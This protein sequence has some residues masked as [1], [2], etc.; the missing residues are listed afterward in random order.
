MA[1]VIL[2][3]AGAIVGNAL[4]PGLGGA[5]L[6]G[7]GQSLGNLIDAQ[8]G[9]GSTV[10]GPRLETLSVQD[11]RYGAGIPLVYGNAR[12]AGNVLWSSDLI[13][14]RH[15]ATNGGKGGVS[16]SV[17]TKTYTYS[18]HCAIGICEGPIAGIETVWA[19]NTV[20]YQNG[21]WTSGLF[22]AATLY[23]GDADQ[24]PN[25]FMQS[26]LGAENVPAHR[27]LAS[28]VFDNL[29]LASFGNR[30][31]NL[32][33]EIAATS[34]TNAPACLGATS[35]A[36]TQR[37][38]TAQNGAMA[39]LALSDGGAG[40]KALVGGA[41][42]SDGSAVFAVSE[43]DVSGE[44]PTLLTAC[45]SA[46]FASSATPS[47]MSWA[48]APDGRFVA[49]H[50][51]SALAVS[52][53]FALYDTKAQS[54]GPVYSLAMASSS[55][56]KQVA[57]LDAHRFVIDDVVNGVRGLRAFARSG[58]AIVDLGFTGLWGSGSGST[59]M[60]FYGAQ[61]TPLA[62]GLLAYTWISG[63]KTLQARRVVWRDD[64]LAL[65]DV[66]TVAANLAIGSGSGP[67]ARFVQT[68]SGEWTLLYG[69]VLYYSLMS[70][71]P[72]AL[73]A[74]I[75]RPWQQI[76]PSFGTSTTHYPLPAGDRLLIVQNNLN[77]GAYLLS[78]VLLKD[79]AFAVGT[80]ATPVSGLSN[81]YS[82]FCALRLD[83][84]R[85]LFTAV[86]GTGYA[87]RQIAVI[88]RA[89]Q[90]SVGGVLADLLSRAGYAAADYDVSALAQTPIQGYVIQE[91]TSAR[92]AIEPL[93]IVA[94][95]DLVETDG[96]LKAVLRG[97]GAVATVPPSEWRAT[98]EDEAPPAPLLIARAEELDLP[99]EVAVEVV[100]PARRFEAT[101]QRARR[102]ASSARSVQKIS[103]PVVCG[104][105]AAKKIAETKLYTAWA[106]RE[107]VKLSVSRTWA[108]LDPA[109]VIHLG[110]GDLLRLASV[111]QSA[112][113]L[114][115]E[116]FY[117][118]AETLDS[119]AAA[120]G[121]L[122]LRAADAGAV[123]SALYL[124]DLPALQSAHDQP[125]VYVAVTGLDG[126]KSAD[127][128]RS[129]DGVAYAAF[130]ASA[131]PATAGI[132]TSV[133]GSSA[134][135]YQDNKNAVSVQMT[136]GTLSSCA[137]EDLLNGANAALLGD[138]IV[139]FQTA[140]LTGPGL[141]TL[142]G[143]LRG[144][145]GTESAVSTHVLGEKFV[146][147]HAG[148]VDFIS[149]PLGDRDKGYTFRAL[150]AGQSLNEAQD[151]TFTYGMRTLKPLSPVRIRGTRSLGSSGDL[152]VTWTRRARRDAEWTD[153][154][155][156]PLDETEE[157]YAAEIMDGE[158]VVR[159]FDALTA[160]TLTYTTEQ[161]A[162]DWGSA[163][164]ATFSVRVCQ[165]S[166]RF[167]RGEPGEAVV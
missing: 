145:R 147:L 166:A 142:S 72:S 167:G 89:K 122:D 79:G 131:V 39:P 107:L 31:P 3:S 63:S 7:V 12:I 129:A 53:S 138:E 19:D 88:E 56:H 151:Y 82:S 146:L 93:Q 18:V 158:T 102:L 120:D 80:E 9:L 22:D 21:L 61:F 125:G 73:G 29:Q 68:G 71:E 57:W 160:P 81:L 134:A 165:I 52:H 6:G 54:F 30:L 161:Q 124:M 1:S 50:L 28:I 119:L 144:R 104:A 130:T 51:Q 2:K 76:T 99:R 116:G 35:A 139:Q 14:T 152:T 47:Q 43:V 17:T 83:S 105:S 132:A 37:P 24:E 8:L 62:D 127:I 33:F 84:G 45:Q 44:T 114:T 32:T 109:D 40:M 11:S 140:T 49:C 143:L 97:G 86:G 13:E 25:A 91:P 136:R 78:E 36:M 103:L 34:E 96:R 15:T 123:P 70:F 98:P 155:D 65:G 100:D 149:A 162:D 55:I 126:W 141:Y 5:W 16:S 101:C 23:T 66:F 157:L 85:F 20:I 148:A 117:S 156:V 121:G 128:L 112:G 118:R 42:V 60:P 115:L 75:T 153:H 106:E 137:K 64:A 41:V 159:A 113:V 92:R 74:A 154:I 163:V 110:N 133:L 95:F 87:L 26:I 46:A 38:T 27:G 111:T 164:P 108:A 10:T 59:T 150:S 67:H 4:I 48:L 58:D 135:F 77:A 94:P 90:G 69:T